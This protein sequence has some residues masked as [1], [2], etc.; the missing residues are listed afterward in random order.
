MGCR[1]DDWIAIY[2]IW[3][4][5]IYM[6]IWGDV[7][8]YNSINFENFENP[9]VQ[10]LHTA[11]RNLSTRG[12]RKISHFE[13]AINTIQSWLCLVEHHHSFGLQNN[14][15]WLHWGDDHIGYKEKC[16]PTFANTYLAM[17]LLVLVKLFGLIRALSSPTLNELSPGSTTTPK[18]S[19][20][21]TAGIMGINYHWK[22]LGAPH[23]QNART[24]RGRGR[25]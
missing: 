13:V 11:K 12:I 15:D 25:G 7:K 16:R 14:M 23:R 20:S 3:I 6:Q 19:I 2:Y 4:F 1:L 10:S 5:S 22:C 24:R 17:L 18:N 21:G 9:S 8:I